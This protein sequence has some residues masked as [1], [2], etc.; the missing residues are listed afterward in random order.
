MLKVTWVK[1]ISMIIMQQRIN[2]RKLCISNHL[3]S[4]IATMRKKLKALFLDLASSQFVSLC[5]F[6]NGSAISYHCCLMEVCAMSS[7]FHL[8]YGY[9]LSYH[10]CCSYGSALSYSSCHSYGCTLSYTIVPIGVLN[11]VIDLLKLTK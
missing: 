10:C 4:L 11:E 6:P 2:H 3:E 9:T 1:S 8:S 5:F 7:L